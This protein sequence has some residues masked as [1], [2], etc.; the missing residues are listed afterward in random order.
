[1]VIL[2]VQIRG[3]VFMVI[4]REAFCAD[5]PVRFYRQGVGRKKVQA[6]NQ[7]IARLTACF[8]FFRLISLFPLSLLSFPLVY[9]LVFDSI[10]IC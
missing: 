3:C 1:M 9:L 4:Y 10:Y 2:S 8:I 6:S 7:G 5:F